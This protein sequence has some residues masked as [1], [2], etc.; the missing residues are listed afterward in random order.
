MATPK[1]DSAHAI[2]LLISASSSR[3]RKGSKLISCLGAK[4]R[5]FSEYQPNTTDPLAQSMRA[6]KVMNP[7]AA[8]FFG[9]AIMRRLGIQTP[10]EQIIC[11]SAQAKALPDDFIVKVAQKEGTAQTLTWNPT[12]T[13]STVVLS[14]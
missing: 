14:V 10:D 2:Y 4:T 11:T 12:G 3:M 7:F 6:R 9:C 1:E 5:T 13:P 8:E